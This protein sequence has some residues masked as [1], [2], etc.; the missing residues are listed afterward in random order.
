GVHHVCPASKRSTSSLQPWQVV[1]GPLGPL[2][3]VQQLGK[4]CTKRFFWPYHR[5]SFILYLLENL[6]GRR[7]SRVYRLAGE[8]QDTGHRA[9]KILD[10]RLAPILAPQEGEVHHRGNTHSLSDFAQV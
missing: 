5:P 4:L 10:P 8:E 3:H 2:V 6:H 7:D 1:H 9:A